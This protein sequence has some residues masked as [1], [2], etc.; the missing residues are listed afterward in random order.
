M[1]EDVDFVTE[2]I[3]VERKRLE[4]KRTELFVG[5]LQL[6]KE[7]ADLQKQCRHA[8]MVHDDRGLSD[9]V[10]HCPDCGLIF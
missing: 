1:G 2:K 5:Y 10:S 6:Q 7:E 4:K 3:N 9:P 8:K